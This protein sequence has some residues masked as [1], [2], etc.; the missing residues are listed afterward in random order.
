MDTKTVSAARKRTA[1][2]LT[3][4]YAINE[5]NLARRREYIRLGDAERELLAEMIPWAEEVAAHV[6]REFYDWQFSFPPTRAFFERFAAAHSMALPALR[7]A[8]ER[9]QAEYFR[10]IFTGARQNWGIE[11]FENR[12]NVGLAHDRINLPFKWYIGAYEEYRRLVRKYL[13]EHVQ[14]PEKLLTLEDAIYKV[15]NYDMQAIGD[16][17]LMNTLESMGLSIDDV[18]VAP[19]ADITEHIDRV[20]ETVHTLRTQAQAIAEQ[21]LGDPS[22]DTNVSGQLGRAFSAM[23]Q[24]L[25][26]FATRIS[27][28][29]KTLA[30]ASEELSAVSAQVGSDAEETTAKAN[31]VSAAAEQV[32]RNVQAVATSA[33]QLAA[34]VREIAKNASEAA[35]VAGTAVRMAEETNVTVSRLGASSK[36][37]SRVI[38]V[39]SSIAEQTNLLALNAT[40]EAARAGE[41]GRG[42]AVVANEVKELAKQTG[43]AT[44]DISQRIEAIQKETAAAVAAIDNI[45]AIIAHISDLQN[46]IAGAVEEQAATTNEISRNV[47]EAA[48]G[49]A[50]IAR[51]VSR[52][53]EAAKSTARAAD[54]SLNAARELA[55]MAAELEAMVVK[56][57]R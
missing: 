21:R 57:G 35:R 53:A 13:R 50:E 39:I 24:N 19:G 48:S 47:N 8:L 41:A 7:S 28:S 20:K 22:L 42:F 34:S 1:T 25:R 52:V 56:L 4:R 54:E 40:I 27:D 37:I 44:E 18:E 51:N 2:R 32:S 55:R 30:S 45:N 6:A 10:Q 49:S 26:E 9:T 14:D 15:F 5:A 11:Y 12:L 3:D 43:H 46:N 23:V 31:A 17:F 38:K 36:E 33:E 16:S 29:G